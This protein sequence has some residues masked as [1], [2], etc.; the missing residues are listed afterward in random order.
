[1]ITRH[2]PFPR[3]L[4]GFSR[5]KTLTV[6]L[7]GFTVLGCATASTPQAQ[8]SAPATAGSETRTTAV[9]TGQHAYTEADVHFMGGMIGHH[10]QAI[11]MSQW[12]PTHGASPSIRVLAERII[13]AQQD[14]I[15]AMRK[16]LTDRHQPVPPSDAHGM[17]M[18]MNGM[19]HTM[20][21]PGMLTEAQ[22]KQLDQARGKE[23]DR[24]FLTFMIQ[25]HSGAVTMVNELFG[26][27]GAAQDVTVYKVASDISADQT[28]EIERMQKMLASTIFEANTR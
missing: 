17:T 3:L 10:A 28:S 5:D 14:E 6:L 27:N 21:M 26:T 11:V 9:D 12:A 18:K 25:H 22:M 4:T 15:A 8:Q 7:T 13:N 2:R 20:L 16:W 1:M 23:F 19:E 24:L